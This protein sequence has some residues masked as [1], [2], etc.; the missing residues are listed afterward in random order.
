VA[1]HDFADG[2]GVGWG[3]LEDG[4]EF[5]RDANRSSTVYFDSYIAENLVRPSS[6]PYKKPTIAANLG[7]DDVLSGPYILPKER[8]KHYSAAEWESFIE[9]WAFSNPD[10]AK[11]EH[12]SGAGDM[13]CDV[14]AIVDES[15]G[16]WDNFQCKHYDHPLAP[17]DILVELG[18]V[19]Y[20]TW[21]G[22]YDPPR[23]YR[24]VAPRDVGTSLVRLLKK[25]AELRKK[26]IEN[27]DKHCSTKIVAGDPI[28]LTGELLQHVS[29]L[30]FSI[31]GYTPVLAI[32]EEF[33]KTSFFVA[34]F[35]NGLPLR[36]SVGPPP[37]EVGVHESRY[38]GQLLEAYSDNLKVPVP[39]IDH[40]PDHLKRHYQRSREQFYSA[41]ALR[42]FSRD[43]LPEGAFSDLQDQIHD[44]V[45]DTCEAAH[46]CGFTRLRATL[47]LASVLGITSSPLIGRTYIKDRYG[48]CHQLA[49]EDRLK[50]VPSGDSNG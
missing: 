8:V 35:G 5:F 41:E 16:I 30:D 21:K 44:G 26:L 15:A 24:F 42:N 31:F 2:G 45:Y 22:E 25:P 6:V 12:A 40:A 38:L 43:T 34:R 49:N 39:T 29:N 46:A 4:G 27:W 20:Y 47:Q 10:Y 33:K 32:I 19:C 18:K 1:A 36:Q 3:G 48:I 14:V 9:E 50:W 13:G 37:E 28:P 17:G 7:P 11:V 23:R